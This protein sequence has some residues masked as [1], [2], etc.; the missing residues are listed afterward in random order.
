MLKKFVEKS[1]EKGPT[2]EKNC[3]EALCVKEE[4][5]CKG[6]VKQTC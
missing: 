2:S 5:C 3:E 1:V 4:V 6:S